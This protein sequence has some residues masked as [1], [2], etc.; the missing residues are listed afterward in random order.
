[1][2]EPIEMP[3]GGADAR[4][5]VRGVDFY[6][7]KELYINGDRDPTVERASLGVVWPTEKHWE[8]LLQCLQQQGSFNTQ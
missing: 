5:S 6:G 3:F 8:S 7:P 2:A 4:S 1:M